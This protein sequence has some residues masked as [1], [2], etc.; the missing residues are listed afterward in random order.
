MTTLILGES[1]SIPKNGWVSGFEEKFHTNIIN[2]SIGSTG[3]FNALRFLDDN[4]DQKIDLIIIDSFIND[5]NFFEENIALYKKLLYFIIKFLINKYRCPLAYICFENMTVVFDE[6]RE[7]KRALTDTLRELNIPL[8]EARKFIT[9]YCLANSTELVNIAPDF[10]HPIT[11]ISNIIG[12]DF[13]EKLINSDAMELSKVFLNLNDYFQQEFN[14]DDIFYNFSSK[15]LLESSNIFSRQLK[16]GLVN[17]KSLYLN[18]SNDSSEIVIN[19]KKEMIP[20]GFFFNAKNS[21]GYFSLNGISNTIKTISSPSF[22]DGTILVWA[23]P[24]KMIIRPD[25]NNSFKINF[26]VYQNYIIEST[27]HCTSPTQF[28]LDN[29]SLELISLIFCDMK[30]LMGVGYEDLI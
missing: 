26:T 6:N 10:H 20:I 13:A 30:I 3:I 11:N 17:F 4:L 28:E 7:V 8:Y 12:R 25:Q 29:P 2:K 18:K 15:K 22:N 27:Y 21:R 19:F 5:E 14:Y 9:E 24:F 23:R 1:N 16:N